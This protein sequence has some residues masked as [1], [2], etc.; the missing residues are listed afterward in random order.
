M[1]VRSFLG[2]WALTA[3]M[4]AVPAAP[5]A[6]AQGSYRSEEVTYQNGEDGTWLTATVYVPRTG[7]TFGGVVLMSI[8]GADPIVEAL[9]GLGYAVLI[10]IRRGFVAVEPLLQSTY[11]D[12]SEDGQAAIDYLRARPDVDDGR[13]SLIGQG[14][15]A[16]PAMMAAAASARP[17][18]LVL[19][20]PPAFPGPEVFRL[21]QRSIALS[22]GWRGA[23]LE[24]LD[25]HIARIAEL[26]LDERSPYLKEYRL[27]ELI[28]S[29]ETQLPY[30][31]AFPTG[32]DQPHFFA[33]P[34]WHDRLSL[35]P[36]DE[37]ARL[38]GPV[39][40]LIGTEDAAA[41][42]DPYLSAVRRGLARAPT[43]DTHVCVV[44]GRTRHS[45]TSDA[46]TLIG[47]WLRSRTA[48]SRTAGA[49]PVGC[50]TTPA[51]R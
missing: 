39:L 16:G 10:P 2:V 3:L 25:R 49:A 35:E 34:L 44:E 27:Q 40:V 36:E 11:R 14:D 8:A 18:P 38:H 42:L 28:S 4:S 33:S 20:A 22:Q 43:E 32:A 48:S 29:S 13:V 31:A 45:Y 51:R 9:T 30:N 26:A 37:L 23:Q 1:R 12:L 7:G 19:L 5:P 15:D 6:L 24:A 17:I 50:L 21:E 47:E 46:V 41:T